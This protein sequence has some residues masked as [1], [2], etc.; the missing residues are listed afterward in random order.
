MVLQVCRENSYHPIRDRIARIRI[1]CY[2]YTITKVQFK[3]QPILIFLL[4][5]SS[6]CPLSQKVVKILL[7]LAKA[8]SCQTIFSI[9][10]NRVAK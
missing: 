2:S 6:K 8:Y 9:Y 7:P 3:H 10:T 1:S 5:V 4:R